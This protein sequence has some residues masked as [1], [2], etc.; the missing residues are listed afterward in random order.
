RTRA[1]GH[2]GAVPRAGRPGRRRVGIPESQRSRVKS[3]R[4][5]ELAELAENIVAP[6]VLRVLRAFVVLVFVASPVLAQST[7][8]LVITGVP[9]DEEHEQKFR[10]WATSVIDTAKKK[11]SLPD[12]NIT[13]LSGPKANKEGI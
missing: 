10:Q 7:H 4:H 12:A 8:L 5:A 9:G 11:E 2:A 13:S 6:R 1:V 3:R